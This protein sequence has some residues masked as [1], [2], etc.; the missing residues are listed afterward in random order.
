LY[1]YHYAYGYAYD[2]AH[3]YDLCRVMRYADYDD[4][5]IRPGEFLSP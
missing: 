2:Y 5:I 3:D 1:A 4:M